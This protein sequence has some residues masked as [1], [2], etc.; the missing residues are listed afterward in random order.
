MV[1]SHTAEDPETFEAIILEQHDRWYYIY[2]EY[3]DSEDPGF[4]YRAEL[5]SANRVL[6]WLR[7]R[8]LYGEF[9]PEYRAILKAYCEVEDDVNVKPIQ[10]EPQL[11]LKRGLE[12]LSYTCE[13]ALKSEENGWSQHH[14]DRVKS[15]VSWFFATLNR[16]KMNYIVNQLPGCV[17]LQLDESY[18]SDDSL[19]AALSKAVKEIKAL[20]EIS[21]FAFTPIVITSLEDLERKCD[22]FLKEDILNQARRAMRTG[23]I[24]NR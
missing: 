8:N 13:V 1:A 9:S 2:G 23:S 6:V 10:V 22:E 11:V 20:T 5:W 12:A 19:K 16:F 4:R 3:I 21:D 18:I 14:A 24:S 17:D 15:E 7:F